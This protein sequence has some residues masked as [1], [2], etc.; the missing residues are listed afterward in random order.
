MLPPDTATQG[1]SIWDE[2]C[3][4]EFDRDVVSL[5]HQNDVPG[6]ARIYE[7]NDNSTASGP[8]SLAIERQVADDVAF[9]AA[10]REGVTAV[11]AVTLELKEEGLRVMLAANEGVEDIVKEALEKVFRALEDC[12]RLSNSLPL[13]WSSGH[14]DA[15]PRNFS[16]GM[17]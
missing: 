8:F 17:C 12:A 1:K 11:T 13:A 4:A 5:R 15:H 9:V 7:L 10:F 14:A 6:T 16:P 3:R 2:V